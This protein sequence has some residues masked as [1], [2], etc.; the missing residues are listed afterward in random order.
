MSS[1]LFFAIVAVVE[2]QVARRHAPTADFREL[3]GWQAQNK[4]SCTN[5]HV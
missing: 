4:V 3:Q 2:V 1:L 5:I